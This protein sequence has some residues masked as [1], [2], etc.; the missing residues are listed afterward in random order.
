MRR[1]GRPEEDGDGAGGPNGSSRETGELLE[2]RG[3]RKCRPGPERGERGCGERT[4]VGPGR[5]GGAV[6][7]P[8]DPAARRADR[9]RAEE[10][11]LDDAADVL[12]RHP[13]RHFA[14]RGDLR[15]DEATDEVR[16]PCREVHRRERAH[17]G[18]REGRAAEAEAQEELL[19]RR[20]ELLGAV[21]RSRPGRREAEAG[22]LDDRHGPAG[23]QHVEDGVVVLD[24][25]RR[26]G[27]DD[28]GDAVG[29]APAANAEPSGGELDLLSVR[30]AGR[31]RPTAVERGAEAPERP[32]A[33]LRLHAACPSACGRSSSRRGSTGFRCRKARI[34]SRIPSPQ[35]SVRYG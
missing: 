12:A 24:D 8:C 33:A 13:R 6:P 9:D 2:G 17:A 20:R 1:V 11:R 31:S 26:V 27:D 19:E 3:E 21:A 5:Q 18:E 22:R 4:G 10:R 16:P 35:P 29:S 23:R 30:R 14:P 25:V 34:D 7:P 15:E 28:D 32:C